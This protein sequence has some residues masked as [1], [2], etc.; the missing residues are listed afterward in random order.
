MNSFGVITFQAKQDAGILPGAITA[1]EG[2]SLD[3]L[4]IQLGSP[5]AANP[6]SAFTENRFINTGGNSLYLSQADQSVLQYAM[7]R[8]D[9]INLV[10][11]DSAG[12]GF[13]YGSYIS[14]GAIT[15]EG[16]NDPG[17]YFSANNQ[18]SGVQ[19]ATGAGNNAFTLTG[20]IKNNGAYI[21]PVAGGVVNPKMVFATG[22]DT[23]QPVVNNEFDFSWIDGTYF[24]D[25]PSRLLMHLMRSG[26]LL[27]GGIDTPVGSE[28]VRIFK[29]ELDYN[30][31][32]LVETDYANDNYVTA[33][34]R[35][36]Q[37]QFYI[38]T[39]DNFTTL[40][41]QDFNTNNVLTLYGFDIL[42][43]KAYIRAEGTSRF[44]FEGASG[45]VLGSFT[46]AGD[47]N[48]SGRIGA[49]IAPGTPPT[50]NIEIKAGTAAA[51]TAPLKFNPGTNLTAPVNGVMEFDGT[52]LYF[53]VGGVR[54]TVTLV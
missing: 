26:Q 6:W 39:T 36:R 7:L 47:F 19:V 11:D 23:T 53:T 52:N 3:G 30:P 18:N 20:A 27:I 14:P 32:L 28:T 54:K 13:I 25:T 12:T 45:V 38:Q 15:V 48:I 46:Q 42:N 9:A 4:D 2:I 41:M 10:N 16:A 49:G 44:D 35:G 51:G 43:N 1:S 8:P 21:Q 33:I 34:I 5:F 17:P 24:G 31:A 50:A 40:I 37:D 22:S 29:S